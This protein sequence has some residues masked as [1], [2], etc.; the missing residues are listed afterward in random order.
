MAGG[1]F[2]IPRYFAY[3]L[4]LAGGTFFIP[5]SFAYCC[6][7]CISILLPLRMQRRGHE[8]FNYIETS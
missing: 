3:V 5:R 7:A 8:S 1:T 4:S 6:C 2:F